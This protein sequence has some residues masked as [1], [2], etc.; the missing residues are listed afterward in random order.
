MDFSIGPRIAETRRRAGLA[1]EDVARV[2]RVPAPALALLEGGGHADLST[3]AIARVARA[4]DVDVSEWSSEPL[5]TSQPS[6]FFRQSG[7]PDFFSA[8][9]GVV[10]NA[11]EEARAVDAVDTLLR[12]RYKR[13]DFQP[14]EV[15]AVPY[16]QGYEL[17]QRVRR[18]LGNDV[19]PLGNVRDLIEDEFGVPVL[20]SDFH[21]SNLLAL[22]AKESASSHVAVI[23]NAKRS[24]SRRVDLAHELAHVLFDAPAREFDYWIDTDDGREIDGSKTEKRAR[25]FAAEL[26]LPQRGLIAK[27]GQPESRIHERSSPVA[28]GELVK[29]VG[30]YFR[31]PPELTTNHLANQSYIS[32]EIREEVLKS[33]RFASPMATRRPRMLHRRLAEALARGLLTQ[34]RAREL[35]GL[36]AWDS[37][38]PTVQPAP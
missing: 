12:R 26:L 8:D 9:R 33:L 11:L 4:L 37:L 38:P 32:K 3:A 22:T 24:G 35:L 6:L 13:A 30:E 31:T 2:A 7:V 23:A 14:V 28:A 29:Q 34:M 16:Q 17:A 10:V 21:A 1:I 25:A 19:E 5:T 15:G 27:F 18:A 20:F 36:S